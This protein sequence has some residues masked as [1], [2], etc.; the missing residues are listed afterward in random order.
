MRD[1]RFSQVGTLHIAAREGVIT[2]LIFPN[3][4]DLFKISGDRGV[5]LDGAGTIPL[6]V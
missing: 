3:R 5:G 6:W 2:Q 1:R 4:E